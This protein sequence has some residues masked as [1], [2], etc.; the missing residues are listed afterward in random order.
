MGRIALSEDIAREG[1]KDSTPEELTEMVI[2]ALVRA[3]ALEQAIYDALGPGRFGWE[4]LDAEEM[5]ERLT[6]A[7]DPFEIGEMESTA[8]QVDAERAKLAA[9]NRGEPIKINPPGYYSIRA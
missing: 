1:L 8:A 7:Y 2:N 3:D 9:W 6:E 5:A 4:L